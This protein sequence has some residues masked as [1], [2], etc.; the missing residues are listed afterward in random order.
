[1]GTLVSRL[2]MEERRQGPNT[3]VWYHRAEGSQ[4]QEQDQEEAGASLG[5]GCGSI[6]TSRAQG[7]PSLCFLGCHTEIPMDSG[8]AC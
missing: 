2:R 5:R 3:H 8:F 6:H 4:H 7:G 1:M